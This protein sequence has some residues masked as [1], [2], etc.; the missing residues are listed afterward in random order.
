MSNLV[1][2]EWWD[3]LSNISVSV[4]IWGSL[5]CCFSKCNCFNSD[6]KIVLIL[7]CCVLLLMLLFWPRESKTKFVRERKCCHEKTQNLH[8]HELLVTEESV[9]SS[10]KFGTELTTNLIGLEPQNSFEGGPRP[11]FYVPPL[12]YSRMPW[13][14]SVLSIYCYNRRCILSSR[15]Q[16]LNYYYQVLYVGLQ[17]TWRC[18]F[19]CRARPLK[20]TN[21]VSSLSLLGLTQPLTL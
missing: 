7:I 12:I 5:L 6:L 21:R 8:I 10:F 4:S 18:I 3:I 20:C 1:D 13:N 11:L 9:R 14:D 16:P 17:S 19:Y 2:R 15:P